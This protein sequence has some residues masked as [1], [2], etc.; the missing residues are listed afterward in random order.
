MANPIRLVISR[1]DDRIVIMI[2]EQDDDVRSHAVVT[3]DEAYCATTAIRRMVQSREKRSLTL[4]SD[5][6]G[7]RIER[8]DH[9]QS[10]VEIHIEDD[11]GVMVVDMTKDD[12][13]GVADML[14]GAHRATHSFH[15]MATIVGGMRRIEHRAE[16]EAIIP[17]PDHDGMS[18]ARLVGSINRRIQ[19][20][21]PEAKN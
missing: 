18:E 13:L 9:P 17:Q 4:G 11:A 2:P 1:S 21:R 5:V 14:W 6:S 3:E 7:F 20:R 12:A 19:G 8:V 10:P 15:A 16:G